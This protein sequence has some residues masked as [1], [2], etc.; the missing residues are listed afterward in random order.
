[1]LSKEYGLT[2]YV[3][4]GTICAVIPFPLFWVG[5]QCVKTGEYW[6]LLIFGTTAFLSWFSAYYF[7]RGAREI[8]RTK[9]K[10]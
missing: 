5:Y 7:F 9:N 2:Y 10:P 6:P 1:M 3:V 4:L 8:K